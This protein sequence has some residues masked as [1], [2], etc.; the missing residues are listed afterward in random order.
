MMN[1]FNDESIM[2]SLLFVLLVSVFLFADGVL[3]LLNLSSETLL[4]RLEIVD[5]LIGTL[6]I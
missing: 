4:L 6:E 3:E 5:V 1:L 2:I